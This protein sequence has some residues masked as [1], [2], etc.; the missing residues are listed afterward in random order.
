VEWNVSIC[1]G[2]TLSFDQFLSLNDSS[3]S[4]YLHKE[5]N[6]N[7]LLKIEVKIN[8]ICYNQ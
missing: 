7:F 2:E 5:S 8:R 3:H 1:F 4:D 6:S